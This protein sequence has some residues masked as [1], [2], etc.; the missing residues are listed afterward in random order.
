MICDSRRLCLPLYFIFAAGQHRER[1]AEYRQKLAELRKKQIDQPPMQSEEDI[2][3]RLD[4]L[5]LEEE[6]NDELERYFKFSLA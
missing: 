2:F 3:R 5:E 6:L 4:E 1:E